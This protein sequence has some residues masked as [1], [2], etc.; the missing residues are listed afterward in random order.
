MPMI[1]ASKIVFDNILLQK[2]K[3]GKKRVILVHS[4]FFAREEG[5]FAPC[6]KSVCISC[7]SVE[8]PY[9]YG[10]LW[11]HLPAITARLEHLYPLSLGFR[12]AH[13]KTSRASSEKICNNESLW[14]TKYILHIC[15]YQLKKKF[16]RGTDDKRLLAL[17]HVRIRPSPYIY[18]NHHGSRNFSLLLNIYKEVETYRQF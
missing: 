12:I 2:L 7:G 18:D 10:V 5:P 9:S 11:D 15:I 4:N 3:D 17:I 8:E 14:I 1:D 13:S 16:L 6:I